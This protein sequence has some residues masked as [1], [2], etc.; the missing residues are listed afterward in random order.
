M[1]S[2]YERTLGRI[3]P[4]DRLLAVLFCLALNG[5]VYWGA[6]ALTARREMVDMTTALDQLI[7]FGPGW[8]VVY[9]GAFLFWAVSYVALARGGSWYGFMTAEALAK[10]LCGLCFL[11]LPATNLRPALT[12]GGFGAWLL[13]LIYRMDAP[14][15]LFPSIH[16]MESW[17]CFVGLRRRADV[18]LW[19][20]A[21]ALV[22]AALI[23]YSTL[24]VR[25]HVIADVISGIL[26]AEG[27]M[28]LNR[29]FR[30]G[31]RLKNCFQALWKRIS[32]S[33]YAKNT[34]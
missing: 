19:G 8:S 34:I 22:C 6:Q 9:V 24:A 27:V 3:L 30:W 33:R 4:G 7:P 14:R 25:Q 32:E 18:P 16:C 10:L 23:C 29:C 17:L 21:T 12:R 1:D 5:L 31:T 2:R 28:H 13:G 15:N 20:K 26:L 11:A